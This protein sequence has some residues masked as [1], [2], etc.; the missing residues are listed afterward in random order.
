M[1]KQ[2]KIVLIIALSY[3]IYFL[4]GKIDYEEWLT[5]SV[6]IGFIIGIL[7]GNILASD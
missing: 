2:I 4:Y 5:Y 1:S 7:L 3:I 6:C